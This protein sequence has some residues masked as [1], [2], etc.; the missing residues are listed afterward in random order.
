MNSRVFN[1]LSANEVSC[2]NILEG[3]I[4]PDAYVRYNEDL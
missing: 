3:D 4:W 2:Q 1:D